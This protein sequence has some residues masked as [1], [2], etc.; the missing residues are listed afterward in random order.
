MGIAL[1]RFKLG[2]LIEKVNLRIIHVDEAV[3]RN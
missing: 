3:I 1:E 2:T